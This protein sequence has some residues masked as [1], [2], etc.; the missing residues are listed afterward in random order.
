[1]CVCVTVFTAIH[2]YP[3]AKCFVMCIKDRLPDRRH[4][5]LNLHTCV[6]NFS[7]SVS[8]S[9]SLSTSAKRHEQVFPSKYEVNLCGTIGLHFGHKLTVDTGG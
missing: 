9:V 5:C 7:Q 4:S 3:T 1:M 8:Q 6:I 2:G